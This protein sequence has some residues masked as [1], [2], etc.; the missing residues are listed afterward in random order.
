MIDARKF[1][2]NV[3]S[4]DFDGKGSVMIVGKS[5]LIARLSG[6]VPTT[7]DVRGTAVNTERY[8]SNES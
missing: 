7:G 3:S 4:T 8:E 6:T 2:G 1:T 5:E